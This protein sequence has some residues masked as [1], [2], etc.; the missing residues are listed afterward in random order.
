M[1][2]SI[3]TR[4]PVIFSYH[5]QSP[6]LNGSIRTR[7]FLAEPVVCR[8]CLLILCSE[9]EEPVQSWLHP[10]PDFYYLY[11]ADNWDCPSYSFSFPFMDQ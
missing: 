4:K 7:A 6:D 10:I 3:G 11:L 1:T 9:L 5:L 8:F 2:A